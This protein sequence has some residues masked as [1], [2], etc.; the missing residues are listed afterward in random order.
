MA[1]SSKK[2]PALS[3]SEVSENRKQPEIAVLLKSKFELFWVY[4][5]REKKLQEL[6]TEMKKLRKQ[7][8]NAEQKYPELLQ[9]K[10]CADRMFRTNLMDICAEDGYRVWIHAEDKEEA[11]D[12]EKRRHEKKAKEKE[13][14][15]TKKAK[16]VVENA[17]NS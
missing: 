3:N 8:N 14:K 12:I 2:R 10:G 17:T 11:H 1:T 6:E 5:E 13:T 4:L 15:K 16:M 7:Q 9:A